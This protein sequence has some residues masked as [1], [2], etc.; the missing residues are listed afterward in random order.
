ME[1]G[2]SSGHSRGAVTT[3]G[4]AEKKKGDEAKELVL[5]LIIDAEKFKATLNPPKGNEIIRNIGDF[6]DQQ[7]PGVHNPDQEHLDDDDFFHIT[8][9]VDPTV[10]SK[11]ER[12]EYVDFEKLLMRDRFWCRG[13][14]TKLEFYHHDGHTYLAP[15][16]R[17]F[18]INNVRKWEQAFRVYVT[19]Y[20]K[21][22]PHRAA[23]IWQYVYVINTAASS[24]VWE[25]VAF[26]DFTFRHDV[27]Q[28]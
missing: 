21:A 25:N 11:I 20:S 10:K 2:E 12:G 9:H 23:E 26:Y 28:S 8:C 22:N 4:T 13:D 6:Q 16:E 7:Y 19:I 14:D 18:K 15:P 27:T 3:D 5:Q 17:E 24:Y 1:K